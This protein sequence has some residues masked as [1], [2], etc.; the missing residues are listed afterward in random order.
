VDK[1]LSIST[2][3]SPDEGPDA[4]DDDP[5]DDEIL[6]CAVEAEADYLVSGDSHLIELG[7]YDGID[8]VEPAEFIRE[9]D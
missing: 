3:L 4:V 7:V 2:V 6:A 5:S 8:I 1:I 9:I